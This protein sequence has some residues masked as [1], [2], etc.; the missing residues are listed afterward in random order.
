MEQEKPPFLKAI[1]PAAHG[2]KNM[3]NETNTALTYQTKL[4]GFCKGLVEVRKVYSDMTTLQLT[5]LLEIAGKGDMSGTEIANTLGIHK[6]V[7]SRIVGV[8]SDVRV[9]GRQSE[10]LGLVSI[11]EDPLNR[12]VRRIKLTAKGHEFMSI[13]IDTI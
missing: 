8:L 7:V 11:N 10:G 3:T 4:K 2:D 6:A 12:R 9:S 1:G 5:V 13:L